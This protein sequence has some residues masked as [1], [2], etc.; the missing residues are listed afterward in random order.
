MYVVCSQS[1]FV[2]SSSPSTPSVSMLFYSIRTKDVNSGLRM[3]VSDVG[4][5]TKDVGIR[6][7]GVNIRIKNVSIRC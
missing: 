3:L 6:T 1:L 5:R 7:K 2:F 4:I